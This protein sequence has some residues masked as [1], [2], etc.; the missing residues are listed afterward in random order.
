VF[1]FGRTPAPDS[2]AGTTP[3]DVRL[4][5]RDERLLGGLCHVGRCQQVAD[6]GKWP[7]W[8]PYD[9]QND[10]YLELGSEIAARRGL[11][12]LEHDALDALARQQGDVRR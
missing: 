6:G 3:Y 9:T 8:P 1:S 7:R 5:R 2:R 12:T 11:R 10:A 4:R